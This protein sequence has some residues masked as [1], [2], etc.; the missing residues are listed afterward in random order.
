MRYRPEEVR[1]HRDEAGFT[2]IELMVVVLIIA[3][4]LAIAVPSFLGARDRASDRKAQSDLRNA[5]TNELVWFSDDTSSFT[6]DLVELR[7]LDGSLG[8]TNDASDLTT[9]EGS[10]YVYL[11]T[12]SGRA[13]VVVGSEGRKGTC[14]WLRA[15]AG[16]DAPRFAEN[17]CAVPANAD[18]VGAWD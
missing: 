18:F 10:V 16:L 9:V 17:D 14:F 3:V 7:K 4:L 5:H 13:A 1:R 12:V 6:A 15:V 11:T 2:L 8:W